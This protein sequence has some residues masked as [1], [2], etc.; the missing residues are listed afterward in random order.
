VTSASVEV[1]GWYPTTMKTT[2]E[3][4]NLSVTAAAALSR[5]A[6][7]MSHLAAGWLWAW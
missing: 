5:D 1:Y 7:A 2:S 3:F 6:Y 4:Q